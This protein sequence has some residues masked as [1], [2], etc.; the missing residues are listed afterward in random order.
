VRKVPTVEGRE[1]GEHR[2]AMLAAIGAV[3]QIKLVVVVDDDVDIYDDTAMLGALARRFQA[4]DPLGG[5]QRL[6]VVPNVKG[7]SYDPSSLH[8]EYPNA[9]LLVDCT[10]RSDLSD[11]QRASFEEARVAGSDRIDLDAYLAEG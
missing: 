5:E 9:K 11:E 6:L 8:R 2:N 7:A 4:V 3:P 1:R 10:L